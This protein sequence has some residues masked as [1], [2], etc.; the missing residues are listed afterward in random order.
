MWAVKG[1]G[2]VCT[3]D[4]VCLRLPQGPA[5]AAAPAATGI[6]THKARYLR[7]AVLARFVLVF[8]GGGLQLQDQGTYDW[9]GQICQ[10]WG[11]RLG[12]GK[13]GNECLLLL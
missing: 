5:T 6:K 10:N 9:K 13:L 7:D 4:K 2:V 8:W 12:V 3:F 1:W 11:V